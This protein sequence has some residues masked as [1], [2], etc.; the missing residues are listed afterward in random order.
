VPR[1]SPDRLVL[2]G[3]LGQR[4]L[5]ETLATREFLVTSDSRVQKD[6]REM[7]VSLVL[8]DH[9]VI[10]D[11]RDKQAHQVHPVHKVKQVYKVQR[12]ALVIPASVVHLVSLAAAEP[13]A[14][15]VLLGLLEHPERQVTLVIQGL[16]VRLV[17]DRRVQL[18]RQVLL[19]SLAQLVFRVELELLDK[20]VERV[21]Q[22]SRVIQGSQALLDQK[23]L[24]VR[25]ELQV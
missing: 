22:D 13:L 16:K 15:Q 17:L 8:K 24:S 10:K 7:Q 11:N 14:T 23:E 19:D 12:E 18:A 6:H 2:L 3:N 4:E 9:L 21:K 20:L 1:D 25:L 5:K